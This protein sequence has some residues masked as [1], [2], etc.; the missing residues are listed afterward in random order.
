MEVEMKVKIDDID[1]LRKKLESMG[2]NFNEAVDQ[3]DV[4]FKKK[5]FDSKP[6]GP[7]AWILRIRD[8]E[9]E[10]A[11]TLK[12]LTEVTGAWLEHE[13]GIDNVEQARKIMET[14]GLINVFTFHKKRIH[15]RMGEFEVLLD[16]VTELGRYVEV[17]LDSAEEEKEK[18]RTKI[19]EFIKTL[20]YEEKDFEK[21]GYGEI[22]GE[23]MGHKFDGMR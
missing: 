15:G 18:T 12:A 9:G 5:G 20:G 11:L 19:I 16:D 17:A 6:E 7:G 21:R 8:S 13:T 10:K 22:M 14:M 1:A 2:A 3:T 23:K 4:Y